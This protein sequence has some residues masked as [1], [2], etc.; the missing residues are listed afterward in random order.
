MNR[1]ALE[2]LQRAMSYPHWHLCEDHH[3]TDVLSL[4]RYGLVELQRSDLGNVLFFRIALPEWA[5][6]ALEHSDNGEMI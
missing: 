6:L 4:E 1:K 2:L 5:H 3:E